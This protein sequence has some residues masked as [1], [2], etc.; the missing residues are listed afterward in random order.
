MLARE[1]FNSDPFYQMAAEGLKVGRAFPT[2]P[3]WGLVENKLT[4][5]FTAIW[6]D[7]LARPEADIHAIV[8]DQ[9]NDTAQR[10]SS[11]LAY[12]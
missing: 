11:T 8:D 6:D 2:F 10:L 5:A 12:Y 7:I 4:E 3:L 9:L 1:P